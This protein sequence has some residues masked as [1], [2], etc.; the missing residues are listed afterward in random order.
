MFSILNVVMTGYYLIAYERTVFTV[1]LKSYDNSRRTTGAEQCSPTCMT[2]IPETEV[3]TSLK[4]R[5]PLPI[6]WQENHFLTPYRN[7]PKSY[8]MI[9]VIV[10]TDNFVWHIIQT[11]SRMQYSSKFEPF[12][13]QF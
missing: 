10:R 1:R 13:V 8:S 3:H 4:H 6:G 2:G 9:W 5:K 11:I 12:G 7:T